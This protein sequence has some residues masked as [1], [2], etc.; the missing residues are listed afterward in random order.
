[1][2]GPQFLFCTLFS[3]ISF[4]TQFLK[5]QYEY[6]LRDLTFE[7]HRCT[8]NQMQIVAQKLIQQILLSN[9][10]CM[11]LNPNTFFQFEL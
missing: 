3:H 7:A 5:K 6:Y 2:Y 11:F 9:F 4:T 10:S 8:A 1:M